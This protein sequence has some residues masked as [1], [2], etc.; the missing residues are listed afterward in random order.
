[1][2]ETRAEKIE[3]GRLIFSTP[4]A[5]KIRSG[6]MGIVLREVLEEPSLMVF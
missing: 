1:M 4:S 6:S 3:G 5:M 2:F